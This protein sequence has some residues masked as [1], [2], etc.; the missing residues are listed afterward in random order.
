MQQLISRIINSSNTP[1][2]QQAAKY[3]VH[4]LALSVTLALFLLLVPYAHHQ[5]G[6]LF[7]VQA[8]IV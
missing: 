6:P 5:L 8:R 2:Q 4:L 1:Q 3:K 7:L